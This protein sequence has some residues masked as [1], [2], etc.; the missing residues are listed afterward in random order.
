MRI[1]M[2]LILT[3][4]LFGTGTLTAQE[5]RLAHQEKWVKARAE[6]MA[7]RMAYEY[8]LTD[9]QERELQKANE[10]WLLECGDYPYHH[11]TYRHRGRYGRRWHRHG[12]CPGYYDSHHYDGGCCYEDWMSDEERARY[13]AA[14][15]EYEDALKCILSKEQYKDYR[16]QREATE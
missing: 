6:R 5:N 11:E 13:E 8:G 2:I 12:C 7:S 1:I 9:E 16:E 3:F 15:K 4:L 10:V 14:C